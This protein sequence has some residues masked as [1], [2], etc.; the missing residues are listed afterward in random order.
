MV[1]GVLKALVPAMTVPGV[2]H[3]SLAA[4][5]YFLKVPTL[6]SGT[7]TVVPCYASVWAEI[8]ESRRL[9]ISWVVAL[10]HVGLVSLLHV[11]VDQSRHP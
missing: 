6:W 8:G 11:Q 4:A 2:R 1:V 5:V 7:V 9:T 3:I 10:L